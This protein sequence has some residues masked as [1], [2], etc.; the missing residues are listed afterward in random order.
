MIRKEIS[1]QVTGASKDTVIEEMDLVGERPGIGHNLSQNF[2]GSLELKKHREGDR[3][4]E[5]P[6][7]DCGHG[8]DT[9][10]FEPKLLLEKTDRIF[11]P[12]VTGKIISDEPSRLLG[13]GNPLIGQEGHRGFF[14]I[15]KDNQGEGLVTALR[16]PDPR[17][18]EEE[19]AL[20]VGIE[21]PQAIRKLKR[22]DNPK[23]RLEALV[24]IHQFP[25][26][27]LGGL[28][29]DEEL[30]LVVHEMQKNFRLS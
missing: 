7:S 20:K 2:S 28:E 24:L 16:K 25:G 1:K 21:F 11:T 3:D 12:R 29:P 10:L 4:P 18:A 30:P 5:K 23:D 27:L 8:F 13:A 15:E 14:R 19:L 26:P 22:V 9:E 6:V 17:P